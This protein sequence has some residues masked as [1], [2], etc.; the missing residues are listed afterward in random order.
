MSRI[1]A[2]GLV[3]LRVDS[4]YQGE[5]LALEASLHVLF[6][7]PTHCQDRLQQLYSSGLGSETFCLGLLGFGRGGRLD[8]GVFFLI[9]EVGC[10]LGLGFGELAE[11][12]LDG[13]VSLG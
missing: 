3:E 6:D 13:L 11:V 5:R 10:D 2:L 8:R 9:L 4:S 1:P 12:E 7:A